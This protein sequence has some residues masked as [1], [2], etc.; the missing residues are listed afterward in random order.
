MKN[1]SQASWDNFLASAK[2]WLVNT[3]NAVVSWFQK[4][5]GRVYG[6]FVD[7]KNR[8]VSADN[9]T[10]AW[11]KNMGSQVYNG[12]V[13]WFQR[14]PGAAYGAVMNTIMAFKN[15]ISSAL[16][17]AKDFAKGL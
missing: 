11:A 8:S 16:N 5:P 10:V 13:G 6:F 3:Y 7:M 17:A 15:M 1:Q 14:L 12:I 9:A 2:T 4:L